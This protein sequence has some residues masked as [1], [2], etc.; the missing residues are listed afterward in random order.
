MGNPVLAAAGGPQAESAAFTTALEEF[1]RAHGDNIEVRVVAG[2][3]EQ[4]LRP[5]PDGDPSTVTAGDWNAAAA[6]NNR[7]EVRWRARP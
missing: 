2:T 4:A 1:R 7:L 5:Y 3:V 6:V